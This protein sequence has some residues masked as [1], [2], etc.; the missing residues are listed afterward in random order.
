MCQGT[1]CAKA[2]EIEV[3][4]ALWRSFRG[5]DS[6]PRIWREE[7][8]RGSVGVKMRIDVIRDREIIAR[9]CERLVF[10]VT[11]ANAVEEK[12]K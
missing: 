12:K 3:V 5:R 9:Y 7:G 8:Q 6:V 1:R 11:K 10:G 2:G 4:A